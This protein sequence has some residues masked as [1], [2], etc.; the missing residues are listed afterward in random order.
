MK[1]LNQ[2]IQKVIRVSKDSDNTFNEQLLGMGKT[3][4]KHLKYPPHK[5]G[6]TAYTVS[7]VENYCP[8]YI[9]GK[10]WRERG[11]ID[12]AGV[13]V[14]NVV[15]A[16]EWKR[17]WSKHPNYIPKYRDGNFNVKDKMK[18]V[19][20]PYFIEFLMLKLGLDCSTAI[21]LGKCLNQIRIKDESD[22]SRYSDSTD[23]SFVKLPNVLRRMFFKRFE[24]KTSSG[25]ICIGYKVVDNSPIDTLLGSYIVELDS[26][27][28]E[29][30]NKNLNHY[31]H[32]SVSDYLRMSLYS[33]LHLLRNVVFASSFNLYIKMNHKQEFGNLG[34]R[35]NTLN[36]IAREDRKLI[37]G[38]WGVDMES[39]IQTILLT[40]VS[41]STILP[42][43]EHYTIN[44]HI[45]RKEV[46]EMMNW[47]IDK[48]KMEITAIYQGRVYNETKYAPLLE[49]FEERDEIAKFIIDLVLSNPNNEVSKYASKRTNQ[50]LSE[51][52]FTKK[53]KVSDYPKIKKDRIKF[54][55]SKKVMFFYWTYFERLA[56]NIIASKFK[57]PLTLHDAVYTQNFSEF[58]NLDITTIETEIFE[59]IG[60]P[61]RL[62]SE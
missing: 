24:Y 15:S 20:S 53:Y 33:K 54:E 47:T 23:G 6:S 38:L 52:S 60:I 5:S 57:Y 62:S 29:S 55:I 50:K 41:D 19:D 4:I 17:L 51:N 46:S 3:P 45:V 43:T 22:G 31:L 10:H 32:I 25:K 14:G 28:P 39:A 18:R 48:T 34:R 37:S 1:N 2:D 8:L 9:W 59:S 30:Y 16:S 40:K 7:S 58:E 49:V 12:I 61:I 42:F 11:K 56:Q 26:F 21:I 27:I 36:E 13:G 35:Y 44:K